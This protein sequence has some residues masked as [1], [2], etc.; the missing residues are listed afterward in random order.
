MFRAFLLREPMTL[1]PYSESLSEFWAF[2]SFTDASSSHS[3][4]PISPHFVKKR[5]EKTYLTLKYFHLL[6]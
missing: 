5:T 2:S 4:R 3:C 1:F 6:S